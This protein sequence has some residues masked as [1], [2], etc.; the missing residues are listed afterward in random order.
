[1]CLAAPVLPV[2]RADRKTVNLAK[3]KIKTETFVSQNVRGLKSTERIEELCSSINQHNVFAA[4]IQETWRTDVEVLQHGNC[5]ILGAG[6]TKEENSNRGSQGVGIALSS[7]ATHAWRA[8][9]SEL[10]NKFGGRVIAIRLLVRDS[11]GKDLYLFLVSAYAPVGNADQKE[12]DEYRRTLDN[13]I[14]HKRKEDVLVIGTDTNSSMGCSNEN[15]CTG[16]FGIS[17]VNESG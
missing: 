2:S 16:N 15:M 1:M 4:C 3:K 6:L 12:W 9:G 7:H 14:A 13:C 5:C 11:E 8:A 10:H 17:H